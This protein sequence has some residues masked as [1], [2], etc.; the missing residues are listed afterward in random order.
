MLLRPFAV[1]LLAAAALSLA[2]PALKAA[3]SVEAAR[4]V[5]AIPEIGFS[6]SSGEAR[7]QQAEHDARRQALTKG[8]VTELGAE[9]DL[10]SLP[11]ACTEPCPLDAE[12]VEKLRQRARAEGAEFLLVGKVHKMSTLVMSMRFAVLDTSSGKLVLE[13]LLSFRSDNDEGWRHAGA[14]VA[15]EVADSFAGEAK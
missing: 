13:R 1:P 2:I 14:Y 4:S 15:R 11:L 10:A 9:A 7:N 5:I 6:D 3:P 8:L 12:G